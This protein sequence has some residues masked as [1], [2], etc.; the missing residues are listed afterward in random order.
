MKTI[1]LFLFFTLFAFVF[2]NA[3]VFDQDYEG[4]NVGDPGADAGHQM[5]GGTS[6]VQIA[7]ASGNATQILKAV[8]NGGVS[9]MWV[10][11]SSFVVAE[12]EIYNVS[13]DIATSNT[14]YVVTI[15]YSNDDIA[16]F[17]ALH[18]DSPA[19]TTN[20]I[21]SGANGR[22]QDAV[23]NT[24]GTASATFT[25]PAGWNRARIQVY[26]F[27]AA[28][29][30]E[31]DNFLVELE[32]TAS[33]EELLQ[34]NF[35]SYPNPSKEFLQ[36]SASKNIDKI[37][38]YNLLGQLVKGEALNSTESKVNV[39]SLSRGTYIVKA[40]IEDAVGSYKFIKE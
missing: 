3:Q 20:G 21:Q 40:F 28:N 11:T 39:S 5:Q 33:I 18:P 4:L 24:F 6:T 1:T 13:F 14:V 37:E 29:T 17:Q 22:I 7:T 19:S 15:Y 12:G 31:L 26:Q 25:V 10:R 23:A 9:D 16:P 2:A 30:F 27:G 34:F 38:I 36:L 8:H 32:T 35:K